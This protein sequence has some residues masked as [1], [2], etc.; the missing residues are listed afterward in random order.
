M[1]NC[2][3]SVQGTLLQINEAACGAPCEGCSFTHDILCNVSGGRCT[4][5]GSVYR[6]GCT[7]YADKTWNVDTSMACGSVDHKITYYCD[8]DEFCARYEVTL[9]CVESAPPGD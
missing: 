4:F 7:N 8:E 1:P 5:S 2:T 9:K 3:C 6:T